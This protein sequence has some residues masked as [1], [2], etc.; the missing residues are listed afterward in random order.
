MKQ[1]WHRLMQWSMQ[2]GE[3]LKTIIF[4][5]S[6]GG[7]WIYLEVKIQYFSQSGKIQLLDLDGMLHIH[8]VTPRSNGKTIVQRK[9][10]KKNRNQNGILKNAHVTHTNVKTKRNEKQK[11]QMENE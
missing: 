3:I 8:I 5:L 2:M 1:L 11:E 6:E 7:K 9:S 4:F 10:L